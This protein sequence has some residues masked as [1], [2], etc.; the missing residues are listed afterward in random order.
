M[1][2]DNLVRTLCYNPT[3][4]KRQQPILIKLTFVQGL[5][6]IVVTEMT[7]YPELKDLLRIVDRSV[8][9]IYFDFIPAIIPEDEPNTERKTD[10]AESS[11][12]IVESFL[13]TLNMLMKLRS[14]TNI[15]LVQK[16]EKLHP[17][18]INNHKS[19][20]GTM[21]DLV[22]HTQQK[23]FKTF[24]IRCAGSDSPE[25][26]SIQNFI[27]DTYKLKISEDADLD[28][29]IHK[30][31]ELWEVGVR[32]T[33]R[34]LSVRDYKTEHIKGGINPTVAYAMNTF[35]LADMNLS[36][37]DST[38]VSP[39]ATTMI[40]NSVPVAFSYLNVCSGS[41][42]LLIEAGIEISIQDNEIGNKASERKP[43]CK[44]IGFDIDKKTNSLAIQNIKK[45][46]FIKSIQI[47]TSDLQ[48]KP[49]FGMFDAIVSDLPFGMQISKGS[50]LSK[51][52]K[53]F[54]AYATMQLDPQGVLV[55][56]TTE[57]ETFE[58]ALHNTNFYVE[59]SLSLQITTAVNS[60]IKPKIFICRFE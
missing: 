46:G 30:P 17:M 7:K 12:S 58:Q 42:T 44:L 20:L 60:H 40:P 59:K 35:A 1:C 15:Y 5:Q 57:T 50:D 29:Y 21:I 45:A 54:V 52:Y 55:V 28:T 38:H 3:L 6:D 11:A 36:A 26:I 51:L 18:Y 31:S 34:P 25:A 22:L 23:A 43:Q 24:K 4:M 47:K 10:E 16:G 39:T 8:D 33:S 27:S 19:I 41:A 49:D 2:R 32:V 13:E 53:D 48:D 14:I 56:Y 9:F 37:I